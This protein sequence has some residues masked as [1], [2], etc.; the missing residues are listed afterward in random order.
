MNRTLKLALTAGIF[1]LAAL[2]PAK[3]SANIVWGDAVR[4]RHSAGN[5]VWGDAV[6]ARHAAGNIVWGDAVRARHAVGAK[7]ADDR[8]AKGGLRIS[9]K[10][11]DL[12]EGF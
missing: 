2:A 1:G 4:A 8:K 5:I 10:A 12:N 6:R 11:L 7:L 9:P 3:A